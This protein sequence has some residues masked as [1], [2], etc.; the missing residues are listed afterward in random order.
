M[1]GQALEQH[2]ANIA[3]LAQGAPGRQDLHGQYLGS[4][5]APAEAVASKFH[6]V[7]ATLRWDALRQA[8]LNCRD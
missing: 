3:A 2:S 8:S 6:A 1:E 5:H 7:E 4:F